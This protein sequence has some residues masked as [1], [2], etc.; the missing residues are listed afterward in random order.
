MEKRN[1][2]EERRTPDQEISRPDENWDK[3]AAAEFM[4]VDTPVKR[5]EPLLR[6]PV[7]KNS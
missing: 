5:D 1:V 4:P 7:T 6:S 2:V 3:T